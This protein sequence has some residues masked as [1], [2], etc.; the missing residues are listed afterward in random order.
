[1]GCY[2]LINISLIGVAEGKGKKKRISLLEEI[3]VEKLPKLKKKWAYKTQVQQIPTRSMRLSLK[4][5]II[6]F[7][8]D[9]LKSNKRKVTCHIQE[10]FYMIIRFLNKGLLDQNGVGWYSQIAERKKNLSTKNTV[11]SK[12]PYKV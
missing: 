8:K 10:S 11:F 1:M 4:H 12:Y 5:V 9:N 6:K 3:M 7:S 2:H